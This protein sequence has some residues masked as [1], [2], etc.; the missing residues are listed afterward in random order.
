MITNKNKRHIVIGTDANYLPRALIFYNSLS[1]VHKNFLLSIFCFD[2]ITYQVLKI[3]NC[4]NVTLVH[5]SEYENKELLRAKEAKKRRYEYY[6][7]I[8]PAMGKKALSETE[9]NFI[10]LADC[11]MMFFDSPEAIFEEFENAD[12]I[13]QPN[14]FSYQYEKDF[15]PVGY[16]CTSFQCFR[17]NSNAKK[18]I[19]WW[20]Q[21][22][23]K[24]CSS[25]FEEGKFGDQ[26]Y[27]DDWRIKFKKVREVENPGTNV[28]PWNVQKFDF[29]KKNGKILL[30]NKWPLVYYHFHSFR[31]NLENYKYIITGDRENNYVI[32]KNVIDIIYK[33][34]ISEMKR[35]IRRLK[36]IK[37]YAD[38][39]KSNPEGV[40]IDFGGKEITQYSH[41]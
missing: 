29:S 25:N 7:T 35:V 15:V 41:A 21:E 9:S 18:I 10:A 5:P 34:Y 13:I 3:L 24:W 22:C 11:D 32:P 4:K 12:V 28:A 23:M 37:I 20:Y 40:Q 16:Y 6:W 2:E 17:S 31:M 8:N 1:R 27:L 33:P 39:I 26:K 30:N 14:N 38:Y 19:D 36:K